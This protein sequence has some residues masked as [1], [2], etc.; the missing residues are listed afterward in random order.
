MGSTEGFSWVIAIGLFFA[1]AILEA[2]F[3]LY[4]HAVMKNRAAVAGFWS[5]ISY[6]LFAV[7]FLNFVNNRW[8]ILPLA[9]GAF[10]GAYVIV[11]REELKKTKKRK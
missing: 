4:T 10:A 8:Y 11:K 3:V 2:I 5:M 9:L 7:G 6:L 1:S